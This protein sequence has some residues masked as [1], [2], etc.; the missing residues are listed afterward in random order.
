[1]T[2]HR[3]ARQSRDPVLGFFGLV[4]E[5]VSVASTTRQLVFFLLVPS[6]PLVFAVF[7]PFSAAAVVVEPAFWTP[8]TGRSLS[9]STFQSR[10]LTPESLATTMRWRRKTSPPE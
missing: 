3:R 6:L 2:S 9:P 7:L 10:R 8:R 5:R 1:M 4:S